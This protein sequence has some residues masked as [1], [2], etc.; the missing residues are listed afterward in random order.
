MEI[1]SDQQYRFCY[2]FWTNGHEYTVITA[3]ICTVKLA[4]SVME[5]SLQL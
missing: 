5:T 3:E 4:G 1:L 2:K